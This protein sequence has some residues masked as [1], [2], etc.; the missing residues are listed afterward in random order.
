MNPF[1]VIGTSGYFYDIIDHRVEERDLIYTIVIFKAS[2]GKHI[3]QYELCVSLS[4]SKMCYQITGTPF[5]SS[6][7]QIQ[8]IPSSNHCTATHDDIYF[9]TNYIYDFNIHT[10]YS[11][12]VLRINGSYHERT[13]YVDDAT[14]MIK[15][16]NMLAEIKDELETRINDIAQ[17]LNTLTE[18]IE[19][20]K[21]QPGMNEYK[22]SMEEFAALSAAG[23]AEYI[24]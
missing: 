16:M 2:N 14:P 20:I 6:F 18:K 22:F 10:S 7:V 5:D 11:S 4:H 8:P 24:N 17:H 1:S 9:A 13:T 23:T 15:I 3:K 21:Y 19:E 12:Q